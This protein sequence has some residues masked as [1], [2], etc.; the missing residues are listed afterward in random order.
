MIIGRDSVLF[1]DGGPHWKSVCLSE[2][3]HNKCEHH[4]R[5]KGAALEVQIS[6]GMIACRKKEE[7]PTQWTQWRCNL[8]PHC[9]TEI[10]ERLS[11]PIPSPSLKLPMYSCLIILRQGPRLTL[12]SKWVGEP[13][14]II[15]VLG[16]LLH[17]G[18]NAVTRAAEGE[19]KERESLAL[20]LRNLLTRLLKVL[21]HL[22]EN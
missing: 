11:L 8:I 10:D 17:L 21:T 2:T 5:T 7:V 13:D 15:L 20:R 16:A 22:Q 1:C 4:K 12:K 9:I 3:K 6:E 14:Y 19:S 18:L